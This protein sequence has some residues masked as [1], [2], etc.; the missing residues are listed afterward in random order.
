M[1]KIFTILT[2]ISITL[3]V[4]C[5]KKSNPGK[6][7]TEAPKEKATTYT[8]DIVPLLQAKCTPCHL[9]SKGGF[10]ADFENYASAKKYGADMLTRVQLNP[11]E[12]GFMPFKHTKL[13]E[14]EIAVF[15]KWVEQGLLEN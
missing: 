8:A 12:R 15:K 9:P 1:K 10:K 3:F 5:S 4:A 2:L 11:G 13:P 7:V 14:E 6:S